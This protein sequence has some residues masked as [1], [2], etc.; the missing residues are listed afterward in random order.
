MEFWLQLVNTP[1]ED[2]V[3]LAVFAEAR[4][5]SGVMEGDHWLMPAGSADRDPYERGSMPWDYSFSDVFATGAAVLQA[6]TTLRFAPGVLIAANRTNPLLVAKSCA[7][8]SRLSGGRF[9]LGVGLGWMKEEFDV[10]G[11]EFDSRAER[12][13]EMI[14]VLRKLW[15][16]G[17]VEHHGRHFAFPSTYAEPRP[18]H[19]IPIH[20]GA[21]ASVALRRAGRIADGWMAAP[22]TLEDL[23]ARIAVIDHARREADRLREPFEIFAGLKRRADGT[24][25]G[26]DDFR[27]AEDLGVTR[28]KFGPIEHI[29]GEPY[30]T[31]Q[32]KMHWIDDFAER[33]I[34]A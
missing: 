34:A 31:T 3:E 15:A 16:P 1:P 8:V 7:T 32:E 29:L 21:Y 27:R 2:I 24:L 4:G 25:P 6:T 10:A 5:F 17:P 14:E 22:G 18:A 9:E 33:V 13:E 28:A 11:V 26:R 20:I 12:T 23:A 19:P 30:V